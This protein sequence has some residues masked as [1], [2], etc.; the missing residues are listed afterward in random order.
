[1]LFVFLA[2]YVAL[3]IGCVVVGAVR[4][5]RS[6]IVCGVVA[7]AV[8]VSSLVV[9]LLSTAGASHWTVSVLQMLL[10]PMPE[11]VLEPGSVEDATQSSG[12][13]VFAFATLELIVA[14]ALW[15][16]PVLGLVAATRAP[17]PASAG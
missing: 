16:I 14:I 2:L 4:H 1:M 13:P 5:R 17:R 11:S 9:W 10:S 12:V 15:A 7:I 3:G 6:A 8:A